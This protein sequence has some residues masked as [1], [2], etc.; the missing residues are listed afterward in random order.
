MDA[1]VLEQMLE[2]LCNLNYHNTLFY[3][4]THYP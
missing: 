3:N 4:V 1:S 2:V